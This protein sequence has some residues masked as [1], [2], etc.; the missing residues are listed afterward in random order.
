MSDAQSAAIESESESDVD[1]STYKYYHEEDVDRDEVI[2]DI[3]MFVNRTPNG[4]EVPAVST[5]VDSLTM[6]IGPYEICFADCITINE[7][8]AA[9][10]TAVF[11]EMTVIHNPSGHAFDMNDLLFEAD[12]E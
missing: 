2:P 8:Q 1:E 5:E 6:T 11:A 4:V 9:P 10:T 12:I 3:S 7:R